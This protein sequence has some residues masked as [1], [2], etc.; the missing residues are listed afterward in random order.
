[1]KCHQNGRDMCH[2]SSECL[3]TPDNIHEEDKTK[4]H[5]DET[6]DGTHCTDPKAGLRREIQVEESQPSDAETALE[7][8]AYQETNTSSV[9][10]G[11]TVPTG[12]E[13]STSN[14]Q[15]S[16]PCKETEGRLTYSE[17]GR[18]AFPS[19]D[20]P[21]VCSSLGSEDEILEFDCLMA[22][23]CTDSQLVSLESFPD[24]PSCHKQDTR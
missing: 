11:H 9:K 23:D 13:L 8:Y 21:P 2:S 18:S 10:K 16:S 20:Q 19:C 4:H 6:E 15:C 3:E 22:M 12:S 17:Q 24:Q 1:M 5:V 14:L 7:I